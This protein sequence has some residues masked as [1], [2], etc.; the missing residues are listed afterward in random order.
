MIAK[1]QTS[2]ARSRARKGRRKNGRDTPT[3]P[4]Q[5]AEVKIAPAKGR[6]MLTWVG[7]RPLSHVTAFPA[8]RVETFD[9]T[10][11]FTAG[12]GAPDLWK[13]WPA[14]YPRGGLVFHGDNKEVLAHLLA[15]GFRGKINLIYIDPPF[16]SGADYVRKAALRGPKGA[17]KIDGETHTLGEQLQYTDIWANDNYLQFMYERLLLLKELLSDGGAMFLHGDCTRG[18]QLRCLMDEVFGPEKFVNEVI[19]SYR[20]WPSDIDAFQSMHDTIL[21]YVT[22]IARKRTFHRLYE[23]ASDSY[24]RRFAG[25]TQ[26]LDVET[27]TRKIPVDEKTKGLQLRDVWEIPIVAGSK[28]ERT[29]Y[30]TQ[31]PEELVDR[32][33]RVCS[34]PG[35]IVLDAFL[36]SGTPSVPT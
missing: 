10:G 9:P 7:K 13:D 30:P 18:H 19:W 16:N 5:K 25:K 11:S 34:N 21:Y 1:H 33:I 14:M 4:P 12:A 31:K 26:R 17:A 32:I 2:S 23:G 22:E 36:G 28:G 35:N 8:Q 15:S 27:G 6:P 3:A 24:L 20:R 29:S